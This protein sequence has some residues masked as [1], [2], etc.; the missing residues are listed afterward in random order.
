MVTPM[1]RARPTLS[2]SHTPYSPRHTANRPTPRDQQARQA[3]AERP[4]EDGEIN[5][6]IAVDEPVYPSTQTGLFKA[7]NR[8]ILTSVHCVSCGTPWRC[9]ASPAATSESQ[10]ETEDPKTRLL[11]RNTPATFTIPSIANVAGVSVVQITEPFRRADRLLL[12]LQRER[13][14]LKQHQT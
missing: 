1:F 13:S 9:A 10:Y 3:H 2:H 12:L 7:T 11:Q 14:R 5:R 6:F 4:R 8:N